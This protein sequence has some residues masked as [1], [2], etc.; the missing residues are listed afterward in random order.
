MKPLIFFTMLLFVFC[1][2]S[3]R[4]EKSLNRFEGKRLTQ[5][6]RPETMFTSYYYDGILM[7]SFGFQETIHEMDFFQKIQSHSFEDFR[8]N[9]IEFNKEEI[10][11]GF[12]INTIAHY[13]KRVLSLSEV[14]EYM[15]GELLNTTIEFYRFKIIILLDCKFSELMCLTQYEKIVYDDLYKKIFTINPSFNMYN[16][17]YI[18]KSCTS[19]GM[20]LWKVW[21][22]NYDKKENKYKIFSITYPLD[23]YR[24]D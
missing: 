3:N 22:Y 5:I 12:N 15:E 1:T 14:E 6:W 13:F 21:H 23:R 20:F 10:I 9:V 16:F 11:K 2:C 4:K 7:D 18:K 17:Y 24:L 19:R 8:K